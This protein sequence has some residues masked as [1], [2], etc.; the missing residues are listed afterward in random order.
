VGNLT[1]LRDLYLNGTAI[2][3]IPLS[4]K[5]LSSLETLDIS[6]CSRLEKI[7]KNL[8][9][10]MECLEDFYVGGSATRKLRPDPIISLLLPNSLS[11]LSSLRSLDLSYA[12]YQMEQFL[13]ILVAYP[14][15]SLGAEWEQIYKNTR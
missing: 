1:S 14:H 2:K 15:F 7:P 9:S 13:V 10:G 4:F 3:K 8:L 5:R 11:S 6:N 12:I